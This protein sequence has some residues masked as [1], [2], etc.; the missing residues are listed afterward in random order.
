MIT[1]CPDCLDNTVDAVN[2][3]DDFH[4]EMLPPIC[5]DC[6]RRRWPNEPYDWADDD[7]MSAAETMRRFEAL[8]PELTIGPPDSAKG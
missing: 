2:L 7:T 5:I 3:G 4:H 1:W 8:G 6:C